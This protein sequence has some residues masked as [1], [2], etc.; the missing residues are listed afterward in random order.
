VAVI[1]LGESRKISNLSI[2]VLDDM[3]VWIFPAIG[4]KIETS[5]DNENF[6]VI[7]SRDLPMPDHEVPANLARHQLE[8]DSQKTRYIKVTV[9]GTKKCP[10]FHAGAGIDSFLFVDEIMVY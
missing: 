5:D 7:A 4:L 9:Q 6:E 10:E 2:G 8:F 1:D 3:K